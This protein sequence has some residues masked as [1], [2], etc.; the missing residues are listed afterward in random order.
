MYIRDRSDLEIEVIDYKKQIAAAVKAAASSANKADEA[1]K[2]SDLL[3]KRL[4]K[5]EE[6]VARLG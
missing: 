1:K 3:T 2:L 5:L 6:K 4:T